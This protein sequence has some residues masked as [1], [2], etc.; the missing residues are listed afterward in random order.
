[1][2]ISKG[3]AI[4][5]IWLGVGLSAFG[6]GVAQQMADVIELLGGAVAFS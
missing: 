4:A 6:A 5:G 3:I 2:S 1:M